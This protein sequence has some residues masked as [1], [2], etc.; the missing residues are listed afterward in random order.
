VTVGY[1]PHPRQAL[2]PPGLDCSFH[3]DGAAITEADG[4]CDMK[5]LFVKYA[6]KKAESATA[7]PGKEE[8]EE[9]G[10]PRGCRRQLPRHV[11]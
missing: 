4:T 11:R 3:P 6:N 10:L 5:K 9:E 8:E 1:G 2:G 7:P